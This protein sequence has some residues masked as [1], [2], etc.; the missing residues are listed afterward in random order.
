M[1]ENN[2]NTM[3]NRMIDLMSKNGWRVTEQRRKLAE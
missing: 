2:K 3:V 1:V